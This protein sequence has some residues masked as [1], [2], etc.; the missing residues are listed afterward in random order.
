VVV[1]AG[2]VHY[3]DNGC[4]GE[5]L[6]V[7]FR[8]LDAPRFKKALREAASPLILIVSDPIPRI[9]RELILPP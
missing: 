1:H 2:E 6:D 5:A 7:A 9:A 4:F 3:D 8:L